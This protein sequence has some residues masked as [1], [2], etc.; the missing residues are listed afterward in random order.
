VNPTS[1]MDATKCAAEMVVSALTAEHL[2]TRFMAVRFGNVLGRSGSVIPRL[3]EQ[4]AKGGPVTV[5]HPDVVIYFTTISEAA[6]LLLRA[7]SIGESR[8]VLVLG[9]GDPVKIDVLANVL[10]RLAGHTNDKICIEFTG[11]RAEEKL[12]EQLL[13]DGDIT[14]PTAVAWLSLPRFQPQTCSLEVLHWVQQMSLGAATES[15]ARNH[16]RAIVP[17]FG[18]TAAAL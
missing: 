14:L 7:V 11:L 1:I 13:A 10:I 9:M 5:T 2:A 6:R 4:I 18:D 3:K 12:S 15:S 17:E 16:L 8:E